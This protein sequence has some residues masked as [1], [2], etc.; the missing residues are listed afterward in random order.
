MQFIIPIN[1]AEAREDGTQGTVTF[2]IVET[3]S[4]CARTNKRK[5]RE[6]LLA[7]GVKR[8]ELKK[9]LKL[10][11]PDGDFGIPYANRVK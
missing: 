7:R 11:F 9:V 10:L 8:T 2:D 3:N 1:E 4:Q 5:L 6:Y